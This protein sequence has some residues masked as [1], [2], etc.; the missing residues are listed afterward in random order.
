MSL[1]RQLFVLSLASLGL[2]YSVAATAAVNVAPPVQ[3]ERIIVTP[4]G[5]YSQAEWQRH[6]AERQLARSGRPVPAKVLEA[7]VITPRGRYTLTEWHQHCAARPAGLR[8]WL[9]AVWRRVV[10]KSRPLVV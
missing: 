7:I 8:G 2:A 1:H 6:L 9:S 4:K 10:P 5:N 3:L